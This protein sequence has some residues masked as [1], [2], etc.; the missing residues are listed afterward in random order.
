MKKI[1][2]LLFI[3]TTLLIIF[4]CNQNAPTA[5]KITAAIEDNSTKP[6]SYQIP[7]ANLTLTVPTGYQLEKNTT[8]PN[9]AGSFASYNFIS[10]EKASAGKPFLTEVRFSSQESI[11]AFTKKCKE[12]GDGLCFEGNFPTLESYEGGKKA[13]TEKTDYK[14]AKNLSFQDKS[15][16]NFYLV[17]TT[18]CEGDLC[19]IR[20]YTTFVDDTEIDFY[21]TSWPENNKDNTDKDD[22]RANELFTQINIQ[23]L[24]P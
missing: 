19:F 7:E 24:T 10:E 11:E 15:Y 6:R 21:I 12:N 14:D 3:I 2:L 5:E 1:P 16:G 9:R 23:H 20:Q 18:R 13:L 8:E 4:G 22:S 17:K